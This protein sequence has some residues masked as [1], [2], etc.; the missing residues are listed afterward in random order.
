MPEA[1][2][3]RDFETLPG[4]AVRVFQE[5]L[6]AHQWN[7]VRTHSVFYRNKLGA[8]LERPV[9]L[10]DLPSLPFTHKDELRVSQEQTYPFGDYI[11]CAPS[12]VVRLHRTSGTTGRPLHLANSRKDVDQIARVGG[13]AQFSAGLRPGDR[14]VH[15]LNY[16]MWTG[17]VTDHMTLEEAGACVVP[18]GVGNSAELLETIGDL[19]VTAISCTPSYPALLERLLRAN[20]RDPRD[21]KLRI[22]LFG[23]EA[24]LDNP[25]FRT[26]LEET[27]G[28]CVRN[29]NYGMSEILS[30]FA[31]QCSHTNDLHFHGGDVLFPELV[32]A[33]G[34]GLP[35]C[36][37]TTGE[38]VCTHLAKECQPLLRYR[39]RDVITITGTDTCA[40]GRTTWRFRVTGRTDDMFNVRGINVFPGAVQK[41]VFSRPDIASGQFR[42]VLDGPGPWDRI[43]VR[44]EATPALVPEAYARAALDL[45][46][47]IRAHAGASASVTLL[48]PDSLPR[49]AGKTSL[50]E[51]K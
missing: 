35:I 25:N 6:W 17:G 3:H 8:A 12:Q 18:F 5:G 16:C 38:L 29:A 30:N 21:L 13:R 50:I 1:M 23:G 24:G 31:S 28:I 39:T 27:W 42:I 36:A 41:A 20:G 45:E 2:L 4:A 46:A 40:C 51:R 19:G 33:D 34:N 32:D 44:A 26:S 7:H 10:A 14:V 15:C 48:A 43:V 22:G 9:G 11:A 37:G 49:T 47:T